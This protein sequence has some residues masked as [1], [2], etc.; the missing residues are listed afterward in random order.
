MQCLD[1]VLKNIEQGKIVLLLMH[2]VANFQVAQKIRIF[3]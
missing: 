2:C 3:A 1:N